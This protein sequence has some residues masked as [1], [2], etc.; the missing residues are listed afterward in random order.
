MH[1]G[2]WECTRTYIIYNKKVSILYI[3]KKNMPILML[4][5]TIK[6]VTILM[7]INTIK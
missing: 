3:I 6:G 2:L 1:K 7:L 4:R 5:N